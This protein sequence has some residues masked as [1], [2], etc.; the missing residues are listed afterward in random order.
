VA[1]AFIFPL[2]TSQDSVRPTVVAANIARVY[3]DLLHGV[4]L[5]SLQ[6]NSAHN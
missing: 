5:S 4:R 1:W 2:L 6:Q 3:H